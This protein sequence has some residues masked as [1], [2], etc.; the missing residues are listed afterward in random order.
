MEGFHEVV[1]S[2]WNSVTGFDRPIERLA[3]KLCATSRALQS[4][5]QCKIG[6]V[7]QQLDQAKE[8]PHRLE[9]AQDARAL[10]P[11]EAW[12]RRQLKQRCLVLTSLHRTILRACPRIDWLF[13][14]DANSRFFHSH[15]K[16]RNKKNF[17]A[18]IATDDSIL[19]S[20]KDKEE[21]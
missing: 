19:T 2:A 4:W 1:A 18:I 11:E 21:A 6:N 8:L 15:A 3:A 13:K 12:L 17:I 16:Y 20:H 14:G 9:M 10:I 5:G 7:K